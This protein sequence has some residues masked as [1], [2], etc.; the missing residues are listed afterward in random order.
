MSDDGMTEQQ[1]LLVD[2]WLGSEVVVVEVI[3][4]PQVDLFVGRVHR[5]AA[6]ADVASHINTI[7][8]PDCSWQRFQWVGGTQHHTAH[9]DNTLAL[10]DHS[11]HW[12]RAHVF[13]Q[14]GEK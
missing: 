11:K 8:S 9:L 12:S 14:T 3:S 7:V 13:D 10:P 2:P 4:K 6:V 5:V 1:S